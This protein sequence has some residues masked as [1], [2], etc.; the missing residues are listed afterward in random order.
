MSDLILSINENHGGRR[1]Q[2]LKI[3]KNG[4]KNKTY[5]KKKNSKTNQETNNSN[6]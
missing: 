2:C 4:S 1:N 5:Q 3:K 6:Q